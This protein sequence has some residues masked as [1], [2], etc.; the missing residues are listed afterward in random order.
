MILLLRLIRGGTPEGT[1]GVLTLNFESPHRLPLNFAEYLASRNGVTSH[2]RLG[3]PDP[4]KLFAEYVPNRKFRE[5][6]REVKIIQ[7][8]S[9]A[10]NR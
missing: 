10:L 8:P 1:R 6:C 9:P 5:H 4:K 7:E 2:G 3:F